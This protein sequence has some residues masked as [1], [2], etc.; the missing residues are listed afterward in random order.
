MTGLRLNEFA[1]LLNAVLPRVASAEQHRL[2][3][4]TRQRAI[5]GG[6]VA[7]PTGDQI[8]LTLVWLRQYPINEV[9][10][11][12]FG[13]SASTASHI[14]AR[15]VPVLEAAGKDTMRRPVSGT[16]TAQAPAGLAAAAADVPSCG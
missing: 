8:L 1:D 13:V 15:V 16:E 9:L 4:V 6:R 12:L 5:G 2:H 14:L 11:F 7:V 3:R 10:G